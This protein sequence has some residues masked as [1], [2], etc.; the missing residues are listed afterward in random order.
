MG[1]RWGQRRAWWLSLGAGSWCWR[2]WSMVLAV[3][4]GGVL[5]VGI[6]VLT[7]CVGIL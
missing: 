2:T 3:L 7:G 4:T 1:G 6:L 5:V